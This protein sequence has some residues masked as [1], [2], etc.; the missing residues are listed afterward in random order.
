[1]SNRPQWIGLI[2]TAISLAAPHDA[3]A[4]PQ[5]PNLSGSY[6]IQ[7]EDGQVHIAIDQHKCDRIGP[8]RGIVQPVK[9]QECAVRALEAE[10]TELGPR[11]SAT[12]QQS[13]RPQRPMEAATGHLRNQSCFP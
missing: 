5:C 3:T 12:S 2:V 6:M 9:P 1:V 10:G 7:G 13:G 4:S 11:W 8:R